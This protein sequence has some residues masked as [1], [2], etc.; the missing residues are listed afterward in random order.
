M[1]HGFDVIC[2]SVTDPQI[3]SNCKSCA[4][5]FQLSYQYLNHQYYGNIFSQE[6]ISAAFIEFHTSL[7]SDCNYFCNFFGLTLD[8][9]ILYHPK[10]WP[11]LSVCP[12]P[13]SPLCH[14]DFYFGALTRTTLVLHNPSEVTLPVVHTPRCG[15]KSRE[16]RH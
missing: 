11:L 2:G 16:V 12:L 10:T 4:Y 13:F 7:A 6:N 15:F 9:T 8:N 3:T 14:V 5:A 1:T